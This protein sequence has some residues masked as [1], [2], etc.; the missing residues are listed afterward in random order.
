MSQTFRLVCVVGARPNFMKI[1]PIIHAIKNETPR[2]EVK[3]VHTGQHYDEN[4][5]H[6]FFEQLGIPE[7]DI[8]LEVGSGSH[9]VQTAEVMKYWSDLPLVAGAN[10]I[11][12]LPPKFRAAGLTEV[13]ESVWIADR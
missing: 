1:A 10:A 13:I 3:L 12:S 2:I 4:M 11:D 7:P 8:D 5:K 9:S 6:Q